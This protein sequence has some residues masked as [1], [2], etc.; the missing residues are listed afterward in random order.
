M[1]TL[2]FLLLFSALIFRVELRNL[3]VNTV[4]T[5]KHRRVYPIVG[6]TLE[7]VLAWRQRYKLV[8]EWASLMGLPT[9]FGLVP[10]WHGPSAVEFRF[11]HLTVW[12][13][14][15]LAE[16]GHQMACAAVQNGVDFGNEICCSGGYKT[17]IADSLDWEI[18][19]KRSSRHPAASPMLA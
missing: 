19:R 9:N 6:Y 11:K 18:R 13:V 12:M 7:S 15:Q 2:T 10:W 3:I 5:M 16:R 4:H 8:K 14:E 17:G 1:L